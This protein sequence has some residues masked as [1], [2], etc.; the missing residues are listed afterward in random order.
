MAR[1]SPQSIF[2]KQAAAATQPFQEVPGLGAW[3][4]EGPLERAR[5]S[6]GQN[7]AG[8]SWHGPTGEDELT[9]A[10]LWPAQASAG[11]WAAEAGDCRPEVGVGKGTSGCGGAPRGQDPLL[12]QRLRAQTEPR[13]PLQASVLQSS[14]PLGNLLV[15]PEGSEGVLE[16]GG[17]WAAQG[18]C[19][20]LPHKWRGR[21]SSTDSWE[22]WL[23]S[24]VAGVS[25]QTWGNPKSHPW[26]KT[27]K[28]TLPGSTYLRAR[29]V[30]GHPEE[31]GKEGQIGRSPQALPRSALLSCC[32]LFS[33][34]PESC[35]RGA[36]QFSKPNC[37]GEQG[38]D[39]GQGQI[40]HSAVGPVSTS[41]SPGLFYS[42]Q[43]ST[44]VYYRTLD[45][46]Q[47]VSGLPTQSCP[48]PQH[49]DPP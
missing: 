40:T 24:K 13:N 16:N 2:D 22:W 29:V 48:C 36:P 35:P 32:P 43:Q 9:K 41:L 8:P 17:A 15:T 37:N 1:P 3:N 26:P 31:T 27:L 11:M 46:K 5:P 14:F 28:V 39:G 38:E 12:Q 21:A 4:G 47:V 10:S 49:P 18:P 19:R 25:L 42:D 23:P 30:Q 6:C 20:P 34:T 7:A 45:R 44:L 33:R